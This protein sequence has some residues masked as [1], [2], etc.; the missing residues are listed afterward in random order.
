MV[1]RDA[2][3]DFEDIKD[4]V[5]L[6]VSNHII[7]RPHGHN[8]ELKDEDGEDE[9]KNDECT[10]QQNTTSNKKG[11]AFSYS[12]EPPALTWNEQPISM[13]RYMDSQGTMRLQPFSKLF[14][15][16]SILYTHCDSPLVKIIYSERS[17][18]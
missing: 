7:K 8:P 18:M 12:N 14:R 10:Q 9:T 17:Q 1:S 11:N 5:Q 2:I 15:P 6:Y 13:I 4:M 3:T 16:E